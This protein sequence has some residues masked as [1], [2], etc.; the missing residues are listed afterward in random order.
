M[1]VVIAVFFERRVFVVVVV[2]NIRYH[3]YRHMQINIGFVLI[4]FYAL[5]IEG[6]VVFGIIQ[7]AMTTCLQLNPSYYQYFH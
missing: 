1:Y 4:H 6:F 3:S 2:A 5:S 7:S